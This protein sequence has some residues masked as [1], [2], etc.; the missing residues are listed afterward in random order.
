MLRYILLIG[1]IAVA[2]FVTVD[3][4]DTISTPQQPSNAG[5]GF[6]PEQVILKEVV[7]EDLKE[8]IDEDLIFTDK[9]G[10]KWIAPKG[11]LTDG[12]SVPRLALAIYN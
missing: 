4:E 1:L 8:L 10:I 2:V 3:F 6:T 9:D 12:A 11:T 7:G 5:V